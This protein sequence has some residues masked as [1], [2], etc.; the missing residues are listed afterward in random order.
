MRTI[1]ESI[2]E[3]SEQRADGS[4]GDEG[5]VGLACICYTYG[6][7]LDDNGN[8]DDGLD[9]KRIVLDLINDNKIPMNDH[10]SPSGHLGWSLDSIIKHLKSRLPNDG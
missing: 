9:D 3:A 7:G 1:A 8:W 5:L 6:I 4:G 10:I 2:K